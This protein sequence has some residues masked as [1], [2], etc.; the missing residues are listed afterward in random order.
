MDVAPVPGQV[1]RVWAES[2]EGRALLAGLPAVLADLCARFG[3]TRIGSPW[4]GGCVGYV[5]PA[6]LR[7]GRRAVLKL[8]LSDE[9]HV[10]EADALERWAG[11]GAVQLLDR[12]REPNAMLL[13]RCEPGTPLIEHP[14]RDA[15]IAV[16]CRLLRRL[17]RPL[18]AG[19]PFLPVTELA[20][21]YTT[22]IPSEFARLGRAFDP[23]LAVEAAAL[24]AA[25][26]SDDSPP[27][28]VNRDFHLANVLA[29]QRQPW[30][31]IDPKPLAGER[32]FDTGHLL[33][34]LLPDPLDRPL[35]GRT[36]RRLADELGLEPGRV[37]GWALVRSVE[38]ALWCLQDGDDPGWDVGVAAELARLEP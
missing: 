2:A 32:A 25:F 22:W 15:A 31:A 23:A 18:A 4:P 7:D 1:A 30:L 12:V 10:H 35:V 16:A 38:N 27:Y 5:V 6:T 14:D 9:E 26:A 34:D 37:R 29:A 3:V 13:E 20:H 11:D 8:S 28:L 24:C 21:R 19:H 17:E 36:V 33:R